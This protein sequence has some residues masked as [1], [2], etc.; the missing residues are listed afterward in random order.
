[1]DIFELTLFVH[2]VGEAVYAWN[3]IPKK[4]FIFWVPSLEYCYVTSEMGDISLNWSSVIIF[5]E[6]A[7]GKRWAGYGIVL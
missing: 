1:M 5:G 2:V 6:R 3:G 4:T 7:N